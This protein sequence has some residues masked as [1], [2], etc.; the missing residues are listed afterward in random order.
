MQSFRKRDCVNLLLTPSYYL[1]TNLL[2]QTYLS[3]HDSLAHENLVV[4][5]EL[6]RVVVDVLHPDIHTYFGVLVVTACTHTVYN[7][8]Y[9]AAHNTIPI[10]VR[11]IT[12]I[13]FICACLWLC[14]IAGLF[15]F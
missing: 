14:V 3:W 6:W 9:S 4:G 12:N 13:E 7:Q 11:A 1:H 5:G 15:A 8:N 10:S 2:T